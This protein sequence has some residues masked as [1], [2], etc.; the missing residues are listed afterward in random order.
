MVTDKIL[1]YNGYWYYCK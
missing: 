1:Y